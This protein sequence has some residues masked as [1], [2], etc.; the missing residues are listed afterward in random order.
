MLVDDIYKQYT[1]YC[2]KYNITPE[3]KDEF[4]D[5]LYIGLVALMNNNLKDKDRKF[6][7]VPLSENVIF[8]LYPNNKGF[9]ANFAQENE[10]IQENL[11]EKYSATELF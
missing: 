10:E 5:N 7:T 3:N 6:V 4:L 2:N 11:S 9:T 1:D 8:I